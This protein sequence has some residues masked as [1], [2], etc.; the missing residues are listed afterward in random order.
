MKK[1]FTF[2]IC[3]AI[4]GIAFSQTNV[5]GTI[6]SDSI[7]DISGSPYIV[8]GNLTVS[9]G[10]TLT[11]DPSVEV[12]FDNSRIMYVY[13][14]LNATTTTFTSS[15]PSPY[16]GIWQYI[17]FGNGTYSGQ[18][19]L[20][21]CQFEY[22]QKL[23]VE[24][25]TVTINNSTINSFYYY[26]IESYDTVNVQNTSIDMENYYT[27][28]GR[29]IYAQTGAVIDLD[30]VQITH[31]RIG[32]Y[33][34]AG[35]SVTMYNNSSISNTNQFAALV[36]GILNM[37]DVNINMLGYTSSG[38][39]IYAYDGSDIQLTN[40]NITNCNYSIYILTSTSVTI[41]NCSV[42]LCE[43]P[44]YFQGP[45][46]LITNGTNDFT[47]NTRDAAYIAFTT[48]S[49]SWSLSYINVPYYFS[50]S[51]T[52]DN[53]YTLDIA[54]DNILKFPTGYS[55]LF[56]NGTLIANANPGNNIFFTSD[57]DDNWGGDTNNDGSTTSPASGDWFGITFNDL[58]ND[59]SC[60]LRKC[61]IRFAGLNYGGAINTVDASPTIDS[62]DLSNSYYG[63][64]IQNASN[65]T[66]TNN[67]IGS[68]QMT[69]IAL[70]YEANP[71]F[72]GNVLSFSDNEYDAIG[73]LGGTLT[74]DATLPIRNISATSNITYLMLDNITVPQGLTLTINKGVVIKAYLQ[75][76][77]YDYRKFIIEGKLSAIGTA[78]SMIVFTSARDDNYGNPFDTNKDGSQTS[79]AI[80]DWGGIVFEVNSDTDSKLEY[81][82][83]YY[84]D[85][86]DYIVYP[87]P[88]YP[89]KRGGQITIDNAS[90]Q[91]VDCDIKHN[92]FGIYCG[93]DSQPTIWNNSFDNSTTTP[94]AMSITA[95]PDLM[96]NSIVN[97]GYYALG[98]IGEELGVTGSLPQ[99]NFA[100]YS[101]ITY[102]LLE[103]LYIN[104]GT[105][106]TI[107]S[108]VVIKVNYHNWIEVNGGFKTIAPITTN[109]I[110]VFTSIK[111]DNEGNPGDT[112]NDG[113]STSPA[114]GDWGRV[115]F[116]E[117][118]DDAFCSLEEFKV[119][120]GGNG[121]DGA[122]A[123]ISAN[124]NI[125]DGEVYFSSNYGFFINGSSI[126]VIDNVIIQNC[127]TDPIAMSL[128][129]DPQLT[130]ISFIGNGSNGIRII[131]GTLSSNA[132]LAK[133]D[134]A[135]INNIAYLVYHLT[136]SSN[137]VLTIE[138][139]V[140]IKF[141]YENY[142]Y[143]KGYIMVNGGL[144][145]DATFSE[146][147]IF[148]SD[149]DDSYGGDTNNDGN[150]TT[151]DKGDWNF[152][153]FNSSGVDSLNILNNC[154]FSYGGMFSPYYNSQQRYALQFAEVCLNSTKLIIDSCVFEQSGSSG[155]GVYGNSEPIITNSQFNNI[156]Y[157][158]ITMSLFSDPVFSN[159]SLSNIGLYGL[160]LAIENYSVDDTVQQRDFGGFQNITYIT[161]WYYINGE[162]NSSVNSGTHIVIPQ[163]IVFKYKT[164]HHSY[165]STRVLDING[166]LTINGTINA[167]VVFTDYRDDTYGNPMDTNGD[168]SSTEPSINNDYILNFTEISDD[169]NCKLNHTI[170]KYQK[171]GVVVQQA[172]PSI[173]NCIFENN[174]WGIT[175]SG[176]SEPVIDSCTFHNLT[177]TPFQYSLVSYPIS[178]VNNTISGTT[179]KALGIKGETMAQDVTLPKRGFGGLDNIPY[180]FHDNFTVGTSS[181]MTIEPGITLKFNDQKY[182]TVKK[183]LIAEGG[184]TPD[185]TICFTD[186]RD[187]YYGGDTNADSTTTQPGYSTNPT[188]YPWL[189]IIFENESNDVLC[190]LDHC[191][192]RY[193]GYNWS[194]GYPGIKTNS[195]SPTIS[196]STIYR[197][198][199]GIQTN[200]AS[201][202]IVN[203]CD[204]YEN[205]L[206]GIENAGMAFNINA[207]NCWWGNNTGPTHSGNPAGTGDEV[208]DMVDYDPWLTSGA[209]NPL[210]GDVSL[211]GEILAYDA[212]LVLLYVVDPI[213]YPLNQTQQMVA[214]VSGNGTVSAYDASLILQY[215]V[216][217]I[218][219]FP[220]ELLNPLPNFVSEVELVIG[221][222]AVEP[223]EEF[224]L[225]LSISN[226][227]G[228]YALQMFI[229]YNPEFLEALNVE[230]LLQ[231]MNATYGIDEEHGLI[232]IAFAGIE[233]LENDMTI[234]NIVFKASDELTT[235]ITTQ[236]TA[237]FFMANET[238]LTWNVTNGSV[239]IN[240]F[241]TGFGDNFENE[242]KLLTCYPNPFT[243]N[244]NIKYTVLVDGDHVFLAVYD[245]YGQAV[246]E[247]VHGRHDSA[248]YSLSWSGTDQKGK[249]LPNG[250]YFIRM[251]SGNKVE[252]QKIQV[253]R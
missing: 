130:N 4:Y 20:Q 238:D 210:M 96:S 241:A 31:C 228:V 137:A 195:A 201:N 1:L 209:A 132:T 252:T 154:I 13:G 110:V 80:G 71:V 237:K 23:F 174:N 126:P 5:S 170:L 120:Y 152:L 6:S 187:D 218:N 90:P 214:D 18:G 38:H 147:I 234:A 42:T 139:G 227:S 250:T 164:L 82:K 35:S 119:K 41:T 2:I 230:S 235:G 247:I 211:N 124:T 83:I 206:F 223:G 50:S 17:Q 172:S 54:S 48:L 149:R 63:I 208:T 158:P 102:M 43:W 52:V 196:N 190:R 34:D 79:P 242:D 36:Y 118:S 166:G 219:Y 10:A 86:N 239:M 161:Y 231:E 101:N 148:T 156:T 8:T 37:T 213:T 103:N 178:T 105:N 155:I 243:D 135:G 46:S 112:N 251:I 114:A 244:L 19:L 160:G 49:S 73:L 61:K 134:V 104:S 60:I 53:G 249:K 51:F 59:A 127:S 27:S 233:S 229:D 70:S 236:V 128:K 197:N 11:V 99:R 58:S 14:A 93:G 179:Y 84:G 192:I 150:S 151:P 25:G 12:Q 226:V 163:D 21:G 7:W 125:H 146:P 207:E 81:C 75:N 29:A 72:S 167:P 203:N 66:F 121:N 85:N 55:G 240:G 129:S 205:Q 77:P 138:P 113:S 33:I 141:P 9:S 169:P 67:T 100:G 181:V 115:Q 32:L 122:V 56:I 216:G 186:I 144:S 173:Q 171:Y 111:D 108:S 248:S 98:I 65:P 109:D 183:G 26:G 153:E 62:C 39:G 142:Y 176:V 74:A 69:P 162:Y 143:D 217:F 175:M 92:E 253:V 198:R 165:T 222:E 136:I 140:V 215:V 16:P 200:G 188:R 123:C 225:P 133:R 78:D 24:N 30:N 88:Q 44:I 191:L 189:G 40:V 193:A 145:A 246:A 199:I 97:P 3:F 232:K 64:K 180:Y 22:A 95:A 116:N 182:L 131:E 212:S 89:T 57:R 76:Y 94:I 28:Y 107:D 220:A 157:T 202:P 47:G 15:D 221:N 224:N 91:I 106:V 204:I 45:G 117:T 168:G 159:N 184:A 68:S 245:M 185:S 87:H 177:Y 194:S